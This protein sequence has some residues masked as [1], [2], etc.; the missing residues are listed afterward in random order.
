MLAPL[1]LLVFAVVCLAVLT[2]K[3]DNGA[4]KASAPAPQSGAAA[5][6]AKPST[7]SAYRVKSGDS[8]GAIAEKT[9][10]TVETLQQLNADIDP[11]A[12]Q[13]GQRIKLK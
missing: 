2:S 1:A 13:P 7:R 6:A 8:L 12:L 10:V 9:G 3:G 4:V 5:P 11:R